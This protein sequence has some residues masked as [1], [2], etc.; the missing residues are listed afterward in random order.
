MTDRLEID[1]AGEVHR[2]TPG[3]RLEFGRTASLSLDESNRFLHRIAG[4]FEHRNGVW[5]LDNTGSKLMLLVV[6]ASGARSEVPPGGSMGLT[7]SARVVVLAGRIRY[8]LGVELEG[9]PAEPSGP[10]SEDGDTTMSWGVIPLNFEQRLLLTLLCERR[11]V[12]GETTLP[13]NKEM[14]LRLGWTLKKLERK[15]DYI[16]IRFSEAG[17]T[18]LVGASGGDATERRR[19]LADHVLRFGI[20]EADDLALLDTLDSDTSLR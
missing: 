10:S 2:L 18:G 12:S 16:C 8:E 13:A 20:V 6:G 5:W 1:F 3:N 17:V 14:A 4:V 15:L 11:L 7:E 9:S 19:R